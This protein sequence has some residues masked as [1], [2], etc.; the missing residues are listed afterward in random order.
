MTLAPALIQGGQRLREELW[1]L[2]RH[3]LYTTLKGRQRAR[4]H[5]GT[6]A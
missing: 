1:R 4:A 3:L 6:I 5:L 2:W